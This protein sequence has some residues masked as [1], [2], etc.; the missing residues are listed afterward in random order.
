MDKY[1]ITSDVSGNHEFVIA[2]ATPTICPSG[3]AIKANS[4][5][6]IK[7][8]VEEHDGTATELPLSQYQKLRHN[9]INR[10]TRELIK[11]GF[12]YSSIVFSASTEAQRNWHELKDNEAEFT[13]PKKISRKNNGTYSLAQANVGAF[14]AAM[15]DHIHGHLDSG[16][17]LNKSI[18]DAADEAAVDA[19]VDTR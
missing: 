10:R 7:K 9:A 6:I 18:K 19:I 2:D 8:D 3:D 1:R 14:W 11:E 4:I 16:R 13:F 15:K 5:C 12:T 17:T